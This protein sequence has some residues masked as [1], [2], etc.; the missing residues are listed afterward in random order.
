MKINVNVYKSM[1]IYII[2]SKI[3]KIYVQFGKLIFKQ[4]L[5]S[6]TEAKGDQPE[7]PSNYEAV[8]NTRGI[9]FKRLLCRCNTFTENG[10]RLVCTYST[11][12]VNHR[13]DGI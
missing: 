11:S 13:G 7:N 5:R 10:G 4:K 2:Q 8:A 1:Q 3:M 12:R 6:N 9:A